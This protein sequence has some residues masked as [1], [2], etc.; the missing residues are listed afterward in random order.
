[1]GNDEF[2]QN[3]PIALYLIDRVG[4]RYRDVLGLHWSDINARYNVVRVEVEG[5]TLQ[6]NVPPG[7]ILHLLKEGNRKSFQGPFCRDPDRLRNWSDQ[8][9]SQK[10]VQFLRQTVAGSGRRDP[11]G[12]GDMNSP[13]SGRTTRTTLTERRMRRTVSWVLDLLPRCAASSPW[14]LDAGGSSLFVK[15]FFKNADK[16]P[17]VH[18]PVVFNLHRREMPGD[19]PSCQVQ[20]NVKRSSFRNSVFDF[21]ICTEVIQ[22]T[23]FPGSVLDELRRVVKPEGWVIVTTPN[24]EAIILRAGKGLKQAVRRIRNAGAVSDPFSVRPDRMRVP[25]GNPEKFSLFGH[26][27]MKSP[28]EWE[29]EFKNHGFEVRQMFPAVLDYGRNWYD[30]SPVISKTILALDQMCSG[31][32]FIGK[33]ICLDMGYVVQP[34]KG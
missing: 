23:P 24:P 7:L 33:R 26:V 16:R 12:R 18:P 10:L 6:K 25:P 3:I 30:R 15:E 31:V 2:F 21:I 32:S 1:M 22:Q 9:L 4:L 17:D 5:R 14:I 19:V 34:V 11:E 28:A 20:G 8:E 29:S 27:S 13:W